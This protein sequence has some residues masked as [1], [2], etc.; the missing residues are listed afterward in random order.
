[1]GGW[2]RCTISCML[3]SAMAY[4]T[5]NAIQ[6]AD[7]KASNPSSG[8]AYYQSGDCTNYVSQC[9]YSGGLTRDS[10][11]TFTLNTDGKRY[12]SVAWINANSLK[13][14]LKNNRGATKIGSWQKTATMQG[15]YSYTNN[16][17]NLTDSNKGKTI[18]FYDWDA[19]WDI[20]HSALLVADNSETWNTEL[21]GFVHGDLINQHTSNRRRV[22]WNADKR[23]AYRAS[24]R[25]YAFQLSV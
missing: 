5:T 19:D 2:I 22:I 10:V 20:D 16:S 11:W 3:S 13:N 4:S 8:Y 1:M 7:D 18:I 9:L 17:A 25:I 23:N 12:G 14:Y 21:D 15:F 24:T 6:Y